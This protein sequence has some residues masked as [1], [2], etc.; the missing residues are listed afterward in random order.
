[1]DDLLKFTRGLKESKAAV[2]ATVFSPTRNE[3]LLEEAGF[4]PSVVRTITLVGGILGGMA[5]LRLASY[6]HLQY[7]FITWG[8]PVL[9]WVPW[10]VICFESLIL[11]AVLSNVTSML[12]KGRVPRV[13][14]P[15]AYDRSFTKDR[16]GIHVICAPEDLQQISR[17]LEETGAEEVRR[18]GKE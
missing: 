15:E 6:A 14:L 4:K 12:I 9:A 18:L 1:M 16:F 2:R 3:V 11:I 17:M 13:R 10:I 5:G 8:K 7:K